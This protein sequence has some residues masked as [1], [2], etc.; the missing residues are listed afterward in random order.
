MSLTRIK[1]RYNT[2]FLTFESPPS[3]PVP[4]ETPP[5][6]LGFPPST[7]SLLFLSPS[8]PRFQKNRWGGAVVGSISRLDPIRTRISFQLGFL[9]IL[10]EGDFIPII[11]PKH[12]WFYINILFR[13]P[14][15]AYLPI[16]IL[17][18]HIYQKE[19]LHFKYLN[20]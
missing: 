13:I 15:I 14:E 2:E 6:I 9:I 20:I 12:T 1:I 16:H 18:L 17:I 5:T 19:N 8:Q 3:R 11:N 7:L 10:I 4:S